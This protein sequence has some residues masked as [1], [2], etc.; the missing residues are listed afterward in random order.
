MRAAASMHRDGEREQ[1]AEDIAAG[2]SVRWG[3][4]GGSGDAPP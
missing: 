3:V 2:E 4:S 1:A